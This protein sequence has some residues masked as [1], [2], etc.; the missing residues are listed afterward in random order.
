MD[1]EKRIIEINGIKMEVDFRQ[2]QSIDSYKV[3]DKV[4]LL[5][6]SYGGGA[7]K[8]YSGI[9]VGFDN[10]TDFPTIIVAY[11]DIN[12]SGEP[13]KFAFFNKGTKDLEIAPM[14]D[15]FIVIEES[16]ILDQFD[17][18]ILKKQDEI[19]ELEAKK[20]YFLK[21]FEAYFG[22]SRKAKE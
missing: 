10:F 17:R 15:D 1:S 5:V 21:Y 6:K 14:I 22:E 20:E 2:A 11:I 18:S 13:L 7:F 16:V 19:K 4:R 3:G 12:Y 9:I 8:V